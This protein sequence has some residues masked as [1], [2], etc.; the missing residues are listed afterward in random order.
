[1]IAIGSSQHGHRPG[2]EAAAPRVAVVAALL[3]EVA[4]VAVRACVD[5]V[6][7]GDDRFDRGGAGPSSCLLAAGGGTEA[8]TAFGFETGG[9]HRAGDRRGIVADADHAATSTGA[10]SPWSGSRSTRAPLRNTAP[11]RTSAMRWEPFTHRH[12]SW[13]DSIS[14]KAMA[15][16]AAFEPGPLLT[17]VRSRTVAK[18]DSSGFVVVKWSQCSAGK[19]KKHSKA[20]GLSVILATALGHSS[21]T[22]LRR[23]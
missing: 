9:A 19:S 21:C 11:A 18:V 13:A 15:N 14:L 22:R 1:M 8:L 4:G 20:S 23:S 10:A 6:G 3:A 12:R 5:G 7:A 16:P 17:L 2:A